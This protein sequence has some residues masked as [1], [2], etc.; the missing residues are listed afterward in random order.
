M[1]FGSLCEFKLLML[2]ECGLMSQFIPQDNPC[3][4]FLT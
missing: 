3:V 4:V 2:M 1:Q